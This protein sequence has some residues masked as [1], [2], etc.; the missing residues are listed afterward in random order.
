MSRHFGGV[1]PVRTV[2]R[3]RSIVILSLILLVVFASLSV[4]LLYSSP[5]TAT[6]QTIVVEKEAQ[7]D[8]VD[9]LVPSQQID[10]GTPLEPNMFRI[11]ARP[12]VGLSPRVVRNFEEIQGYYARSLIAPEQPLHGDY[13]TKVRP[14]SAIT[15]NIPAG[16]RAVT[17]R[18]DARSSVEG[19]AR[20][21]ARVDV[22]WSSTVNSKPA[23]TVI[24]QNAKI[25]SAERMTDSD[26]KTAKEGLTLPSTVTL[27]VTA[28]DAA[29][30]Q[31]ASTSGSLS[32]SLRGDV[33]SSAGASGQTIDIDDLIKGTQ[34]KA[35]EKHE[36]TVKIRG[37]D[38][39]MEEYHVKEGKLVP[40]K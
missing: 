38:G 12:R 23:V 13:I 35:E 36:G 22:V 16:Y 19:W 28:A 14:N 20:P 37:R 17:I 18:V 27:L 33:D 15:A 24:V 9:V 11:E 21:G 2:D 4:L 8:M 7:L 32:L 31:L 39:Q 10:A 30:I 29:K 3:A 1:G 6:T 25:L 5:T 26:I 40:A 34:P